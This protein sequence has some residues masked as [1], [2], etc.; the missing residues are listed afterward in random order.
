MIEVTPP[1][2]VYVFYRDAADSLDV[3]YPN[4]SEA[5]GAIR[6]VLT[7]G[8]TLD[9][10]PGLERF[11]MIASDG[12]HARLEEL[13]ADLEAADAETRPA[14]ETALRDEVLELRKRYEKDAPARPS[15][16]GGSV[17]ADSP[18]DHAQVYDGEG[19]RAWTFTIDHR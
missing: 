6:D 11:H 10:T 2:H 14:A 9:E 18:G 4:D 13:I 5:R 1:V 15:R 17:R 3:L 8:T 19:I 7:P 16:I 12:P